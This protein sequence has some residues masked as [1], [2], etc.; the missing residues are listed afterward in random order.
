MGV[1]DIG[2]FSGG[3]PAPTVLHM[4]WAPSSGLL[5]SYSKPPSY[6]QLGIHSAVNV[7]YDVR[8]WTYC[9][10]L[11]ELPLGSL[12]MLLPSSSTLKT[13]RCMSTMACA[14]SIL[15]T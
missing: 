10:R 7:G 5:T 15:L 2:P 14:R 11:G 9:A 13:L 8:V 6:V 4:F 12:L 3:S 1:G